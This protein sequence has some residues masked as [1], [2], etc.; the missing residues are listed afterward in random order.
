MAGLEPGLT[1]M[2]DLAPRQGLAR[3]Q[4]RGAAGRYERWPL[5]RHEAIR[6]AFLAIAAREPARCRVL[7]AMQSVEAVTAG[8]WQAVT[9][10]FPQLSAC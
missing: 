10:R 7:N 8:V 1:L 3:A 5:A 6:Q 2:L 4:A 9:G